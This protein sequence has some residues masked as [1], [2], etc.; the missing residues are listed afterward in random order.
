MHVFVSTHEFIVDFRPD[1]RVRRAGGS[2]AHGY[3]GGF[4]FFSSMYDE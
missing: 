4:L 3:C 1:P 2:V